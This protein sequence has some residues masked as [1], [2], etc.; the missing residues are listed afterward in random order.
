MNKA[1]NTFARQTEIPTIPEADLEAAREAGA[2]IV[3]RNPELVRQ[4]VAGDLTL[5]ELE[6]I[7]KADQYQMAE[8]GYA[9]FTDGNL[10]KAHEIFRGLLALDP[11]DAY[12]QMVLG[13]IAKE[14]QELDAAVRYLSR[15]LELNGYSIPAR[16]MRAEVLILRGELEA[17]SADLV[18]CLELDP[19][20][21]DPCTQRVRALASRVSE[22]LVEL[23]G[24]ASS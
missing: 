12:F 7:P 14:R 16:S 18:R 17:A 15:S 1:L 20:G 23:T 9:H 11:L 8:I 2:T 24:H 3:T 4:F 22:Q 6:G 21:Q 10:E 13:A 5:G 19:E